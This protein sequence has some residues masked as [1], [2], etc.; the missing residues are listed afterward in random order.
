MAP[1]AAPPAPSAAVDAGARSGAA[2]ARVETAGD[3][4][5]KRVVRLGDPDMPEVC[6]AAPDTGPA[7][8]QVLLDFERH[9]VGAGR[10]PEE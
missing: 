6:R 4:A 8:K 5:P 9:L 1:P 3:A 2:D 10:D 7:G